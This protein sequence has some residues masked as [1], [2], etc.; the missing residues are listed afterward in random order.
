MRT[1]NES[2]DE[3]KMIEKYVMN[4]ASRYKLDI[5]DAFELQRDGEAKV[6]NPKKLGNK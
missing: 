6:F 2:E 5:I 4:T 1:L 3:Y